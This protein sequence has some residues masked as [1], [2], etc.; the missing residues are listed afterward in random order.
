MIQVKYESPSKNM[1][2]IM[3]YTMLLQIDPSQV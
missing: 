3:K 2:F 1:Q